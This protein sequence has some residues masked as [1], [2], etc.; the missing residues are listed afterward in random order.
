VDWISWLEGI[1]LVA[2][3]NLV[4]GDVERVEGFVANATELAI[5]GNAAGVIGECGTA[6]RYII[7]SA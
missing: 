7:A 2:V 1:A 5:K 4:F 3:N 6:K